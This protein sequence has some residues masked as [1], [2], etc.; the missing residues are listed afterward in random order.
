[1]WFLF[2]DPNLKPSLFLSSPAPYF[3][4]YRYSHSQA[5]AIAENID[6]VVGMGKGISDVSAIKFAASFYQALGFGRSVKDAFDLG[7]IQIDLENLREEDVPKFHCLR[8][9]PKKMKFV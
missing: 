9:D 5:L 2:G 6:C 8:K 7:C 4:H 1:M 3:L